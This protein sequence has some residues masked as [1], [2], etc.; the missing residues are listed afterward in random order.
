MFGGGGEL[1]LIKLT[2]ARA[3]QIMLDQS[4]LE[5]KYYVNY[6]PDILMHIQ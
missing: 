1:W 6:T 4:F 5:Y 2:V 3:E